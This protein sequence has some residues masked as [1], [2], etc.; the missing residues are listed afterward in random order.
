[1]L[2]LKIINSLSAQARKGEQK[3]TYIYTYIKQ[4]FSLKVMQ[5]IKWNKIRS[6]PEL[7]FDPVIANSLGIE[8]G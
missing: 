8:V 1:M 4:I 3:K 6:C 7:A 2:V 5:N